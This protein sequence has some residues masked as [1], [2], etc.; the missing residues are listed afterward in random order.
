[1]QSEAKQWREINVT[2]RAYNG[3]GSGKLPRA[4]STDLRCHPVV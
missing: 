3:S 4:V 2:G 1:M